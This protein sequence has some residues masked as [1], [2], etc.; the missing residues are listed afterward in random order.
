MIY[1]RLRSKHAS[2]DDQAAAVGSSRGHC[3]KRPL[4][5]NFLL[6]WALPYSYSLLRVRVRSTSSSDLVFVRAVCTSRAF[7]ATGAGAD[8]FHPESVKKASIY[9]E[10]ST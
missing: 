9:C 10:S 7:T 8:V 4:E 2:V 1:S 3:A 5:E 6:G